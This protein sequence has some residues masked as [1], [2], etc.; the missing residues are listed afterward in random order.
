MRHLFVLILSV[1]AFNCYA[2]YNSNASS[3]MPGIENVLRLKNCISIY[4]GT[5]HLLYNGNLIQSVNNTTNLKA[6]IAEN[7]D[8]FKQYPL[9]IMIDTFDTTRF[10]FLR[11][12]MK[13]FDKHGINNFKIVYRQ[14]LFP[15]PMDIFS[16]SGNTDSICSISFNDSNN[17]VKAIL[18]GKVFLLQGTEELERF[19]QYHL[20]KVK[21]YHILLMPAP[22]TKYDKVERII[23]ILKS[24]GLNKFE[25]HIDE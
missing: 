8:S 13:C 4:K 19:V 24:H 9:Y 6:F 7:N 22:Q 5:I 21:T 14:D 25:L 16:S 2:Q 15:H 20:D 18:K 10:Q 1:I 23:D 3:T 12:V 17:V 11:S